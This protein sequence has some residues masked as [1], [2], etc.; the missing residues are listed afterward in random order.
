LTPL[1]LLAEGFVER[2]NRRRDQ[3]GGYGSQEYGRMIGPPPILQMIFFRFLFFVAVIRRLSSV[4]C[5]LSLRHPSSVIWSYVLCLLCSVICP[6]SSVVRL[7]R[8]GGRQLLVQGQPPGIY[9]PGGRD[10]RRHLGQRHPPG[11]VQGLPW[12]NGH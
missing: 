8:P 7:W 6:P 4:I 12:V 5:F 2:K 3:S 1:F 11:G 9:L 10:R